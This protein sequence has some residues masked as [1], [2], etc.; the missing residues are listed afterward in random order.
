MYDLLN[1]TV[2]IMVITS[3]TAS[4]LGIRL[5]NRQNQNEND[6][7]SHC[8]NWNVIDHSI[9]ITLTDYSK[10]LL[11]KLNQNLIDRDVY[12]YIIIW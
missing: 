11:V 1:I 8:E 10:S 4:A 6:S 3:T 5:S 12:K 7:F 9:T 2:T